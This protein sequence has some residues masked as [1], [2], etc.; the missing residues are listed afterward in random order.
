MQRLV[1]SFTV[2][3][4]LLIVI[5][6]STPALAQTRIKNLSEYSTAPRVF[7]PIGCRGLGLNG[8]EHSEMRGE[9]STL[10]NRSF[11]ENYDMSESI[12]RSDTFDIDHYALDLDL[13]NY[14]LQQMQARALIT[15]SV[16][17]SGA[18]EVW[19]DLIGLTVDSVNIDGASSS[20]VHENGRL[21]I[22]SPGLVFQSGDAYEI[23]VFYGGHPTQDPY[24][25]GVY[26]TSGY[27]YHMGI[28][29]TS[30]PPNYGKV[31]HPCFDNFVERATYSWNIRSAG[32]MEA[33]LQ[34]T[35]LGET[36]E[37]GD[38]LTRSFILEHPITTH[39]AAFAVSS[40]VD[41]NFVHIGE[42]GDIPVRLTAKA[43]DINLMT[44]KFIDIGYAIDALEYWWGPYAW[45]RVGYIL[46]TDGALEVPTNISYPL[47]MIEQSVTANGDLFSH[48]LGHHWWGDLVAPTIHNHMW[49]KEGPA[50]YSSHLFIEFKD[51]HEEFIDLVKDNQQ[52][53]LEECHIQDEGF[54]PLSP[55]PDEQIY[56]RT[57]YYKGASIHH[58]L[59]AYLGDEIY[60]SA[61]QSV[62]S[63]HFDSH[64]D[65]DVFRQTL[66]DATGLDLDP[67]FDA[68][69][70]QPGFSTWLIDSTFTE[71]VTDGFETTLY[72]NQKLRACTN[73]HDNEPLDVTLWNAEWDTTLV[74]VRVGGEYDEVTISHPEPYVLIALNA[75][76]KL[77][78][79]R[80]DHTVAIT[81]ATGLSTMPWVEMRLGC[82]NIT[83]SVIA[84]VEHHWAAP[85]SEPTD[86]YFDEI[87]STHFWTVDGTWEDGIEGSEALTIDARFSY[88]G[89]NDEG[90]DY[91]LYYG[92]EGDGFLAWRPN[93]A[94]TWVQYPDYTWQSGSLTNGNGVFKVSSLRKGQYAFANGDISLSI[95]SPGLTNATATAFPSPASASITL[96]NNL[97]ADL[98][99]VWDI[100]GRVIL[101]KSIYDNFDVSIDLEG[102]SEGTYVAVWYKN[103]LSTN[104]AKFIVSH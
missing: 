30:I 70:Y 20:F 61:C 31:W 98:I 87:S 57:T 73:F 25:G 6:D 81:E 66:E 91:E 28:G 4:I 69:I 102:W 21:I 74:E 14:S 41:S 77:N 37:E 104:S 51:G 103:Q 99:K 68:Q 52:F 40:Y 78:Q 38:T 80:L 18:E 56:G 94:S 95:D 100:N 16:I 26:F 29:L 43:E 13:T 62:L 83:D 7:S 34:G 24:W 89:N 50:E 45:E 39:Q 46:T 93:S 12:S 96:E 8:H 75:D 64:M 53:V 19:F 101:S 59:R 54:H 47:F 86:F 22:P 11:V 10:E 27:I 23:E 72:L 15:M 76:G 3:V 67:F 5:A 49:I 35:F 90:L 71:T 88:V 42:Y 36:F 32:G 55:M 85:D 58:N 17:E 44:N 48:E 82:D 79:G 97:E 9:M 84:R 1:H 65:A 92:D 60:R 63:T 33:H 2:L